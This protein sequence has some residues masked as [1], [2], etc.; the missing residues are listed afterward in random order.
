METMTMT[1]RHVFRPTAIEALEPRLALSTVSAIID[2]VER[3]TVHS[4]AKKQFQITVVN[5]TGEK[6]R[7]THN[8]GK[9]EVKLDKNK[10]IVYAFT[11]NGGAVLQVN[12]LST[13]KMAVIS[14]YRPHGKYTIMNERG[15]GYR[16]DIK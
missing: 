10:Q 14:I 7:L 9:D 13:G 12:G 8:G 11:E 3:R 1:M 5:Q 4:S 16:I 2:N 15:N 6:L